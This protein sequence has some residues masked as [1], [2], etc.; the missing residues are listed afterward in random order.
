[1]RAVFARLGFLTSATALVATIM[2]ASTSAFAQEASASAANNPNAG[3]MTLALA[4]GAGLATLGGT[5]GQ[6]RAASSALE[7][8]ARNPNAKVFI[9][10]ILSLAFIESLTLATWVLMLLLRSKI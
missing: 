2:L 7:G 10:L 3:L 5:Y 4:I 8:L 1:M 6:S 9:P